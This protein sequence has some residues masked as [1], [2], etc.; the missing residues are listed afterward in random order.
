MQRIQT[1]S[2]DEIAVWTWLVSKGIA[3]ALSGLSRMVGQEFSVTSLNLRQIPAKDAAF[4]LGGPENL[5][6]GI[7]MQIHGDAAGHLMLIHDPKMAYELIDIQLGLP[8]GSTHY[9]EEKE[10]SVLEEMG[11]I[12]G[13]FFLNAL[14]DATNLSL[15]PS[16]PTVMLDMAG[17]ILGITLAQIMQQQDHVLTIKITFGTMSRQVDGIFLVMPTLDFLSVLLKHSLVFSTTY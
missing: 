15:S 5:V 3:N 7:C 6:V 4:L 11:N 14:A 8:Q 9:L 16:P 2:K 10:R 1:L 12:T 17:A 13:S